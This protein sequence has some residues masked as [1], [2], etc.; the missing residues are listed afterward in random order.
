PGFVWNLDDVLAN[1]GNQDVIFYD[2]R[3]PAEYEGRDRRGNV[4]GG[5]IPGAVLCDFAD[6]LDSEKRTLPPEQIR[7]QLLARGITPD[8]QI[9]LY[10]QT[11]SRV[12]LP[13]LALHD[14]GY[15]NVSIYD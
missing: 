12:S 1:L 5:H 7:E 4:R 6:F 10:C 8:K 13:L 14:L 15:T 2:T 11:A 3:S 9:V